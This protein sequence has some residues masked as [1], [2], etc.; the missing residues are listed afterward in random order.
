M[1][2][3]LGT[4]VIG[5]NHLTGPT[6]ASEE[7]AARFPRHELV[8]GKPALQDLGNEAGIRRLTFFFDETFCDPQ[9]ELRK[10]DLAFRGRVPVRLFF[11]LAGFEVGMFLIE[12][13]II[14]NRKTA[15]GGR[16]V[17]IE[18]EAELV[19]S[20]APLGSALGAVAGVLR[21][22]ANPALRRG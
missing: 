8:R 3:L 18:L 16:V 20:A 13:L 5:T 4:S 14:E 17:R 12:R 10:I 22:I 1:L 7:R 9:R 2:G 19:E 15:P 21:A 11:D 6:G